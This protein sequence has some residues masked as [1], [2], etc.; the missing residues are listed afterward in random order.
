MKMN[1]KLLIVLLSFLSLMIIPFVANAATITSSTLDKETYRQGQTGYI[2][3]RIYNDE[4]DKV[5][6]SKLTATIDYYYSDENIYLQTFFT[7]ATLPAEIEQGQSSEFY[8]PFSLPNNIAAGYT[9]IEVKAET[10]LWDSE[11]ERWRGSDHPTYQKKLFVE[12]P[13]K[14][15]LEEQKTAN[16]ELQTTN[17]QIQNELQEQ[18]TL[19]ENYTTMIYILGAATIFFALGIGFLFILLRKARITTQATA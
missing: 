16:Q 4:D 7:N 8:I 19:N 6:I 11:S 17:Q 12:S 9:N 14:Q 15:Q 13:Y 3:V 1:K 5:R 18:Q 2:T 10:E